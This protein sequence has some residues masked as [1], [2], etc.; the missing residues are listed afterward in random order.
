[1]LCLSDNFFCD[2]CSGP[3]LQDSGSCT[4]LCCDP[5]VCSGACQD[6][7]LLLNYL[8]FPLFCPKPILLVEGVRL[9]RQS[10]IS[11]VAVCRADFRLHIVTHNAQEVLPIAYLHVTLRKTCDNELVN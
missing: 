1:M 8:T 3:D 9:S 6:Q 7:P 11:I 10:I 2:C 5:Y 4:D